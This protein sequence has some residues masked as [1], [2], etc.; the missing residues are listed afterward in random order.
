MLLAYLLLA[1]R[2]FKIAMLARDSYFNLLAT[3]LSAHREQLQERVAGEQRDLEPALDD[4]QVD[5]QQPARPGEAELVRD[6]R[7][8]RS[9]WGAGR[10]APRPAA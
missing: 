9:V 5:E 3:G 8:I 10:I 1:E 7:E 4:H 6:H 2:G